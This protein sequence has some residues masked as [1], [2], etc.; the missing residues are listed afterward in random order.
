MFFSEL[1][2]VESTDCP[3]VSSTTNCGEKIV[4]IIIWQKIFTIF[5]SEFSL[6]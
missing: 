1:S 2:F 4:L 3:I 6:G 5:F